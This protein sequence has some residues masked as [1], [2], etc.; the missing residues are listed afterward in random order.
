MRI[1]EAPLG[2]VPGKDFTGKVNLT[3]ILEGAHGDPMELYRVKFEAGARTDWHAHQ[4]LQV[5]YIESGECRLQKQ[6]EP[7]QNVPAGNVV[8]IDADEKHWHGASPKGEMVHIAIGL[9]GSTKWFDPV[10][11]EQYAGSE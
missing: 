2:I 9:Y 5:L 1:V 8:V 10:T 4:G 7:V 11:D 3:K 6:G